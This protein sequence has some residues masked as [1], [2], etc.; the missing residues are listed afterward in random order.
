MWSGVAAQ[1]I[2][3]QMTDVGHSAGFSKLA[4]WRPSSMGLILFVTSKDGI[5]HHDRGRLDIANV[6]ARATMTIS[7]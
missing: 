2:K 3:L 4:R 5:A 6:A 1:R 7:T